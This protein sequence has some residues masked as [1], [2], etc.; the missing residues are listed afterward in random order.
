MT[1]MLKSRSELSHKMAAKL[2]LKSYQ[3][4]GDKMQLDFRNHE[5][6]YWKK[7]IPYLESVGIR[8]VDDDF[9]NRLDADF[10]DPETVFVTDPIGT[11]LLFLSKDTCDR[12]M[13]LGLP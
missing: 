7:W 1:P 6:F 12:V 3:M 9:V 10:F 8:I 5:D 11:S 2:W 4:M 13:V